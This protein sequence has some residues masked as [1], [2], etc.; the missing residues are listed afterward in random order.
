MGRRDH[1]PA[2]ASRPRVARGVVFALL[3]AT[4]ALLF[5]VAPRAIGRRGANLGWRGG[6]PAA[7]NRLGVIPLA[8]GAAG[9]GW[10]LGE[11]YAPGETAPVSLVPEKLIARGPYRLSRNPMY[12]CEQAMLLGWTVYYGSPGLLAGAAALGAGMRYAVSREEK[13]LVSRFGDSWREYAS[14]VPRWL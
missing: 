1:D 7:V 8:I 3:P 14:K 11:H 2:A 12:V 9:L 4:W 13:T 5:G 6:R 10:C